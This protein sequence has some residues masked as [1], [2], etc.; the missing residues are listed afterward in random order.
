MHISHLTNIPTANVLVKVACMIK[1]PVH[2][3]HLTNIPT[4]NVLVKVGFEIK[5]RG[6]IS[7]LTNIPTANVLVKED[8]AFNQDIGSWN[9]SK[10][11]D[12]HGMF[13]NEDIS[14]T[15]LTSQLP[16]SWSKKIAPLN[17]EDISVILLTSQLPISEC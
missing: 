8:C 12:M 10:V 13:W 2:I 17:I 9:V 1:H 11:T 4:A 3:S 14:V 15:L 5:H 16:M 6:H 7:H